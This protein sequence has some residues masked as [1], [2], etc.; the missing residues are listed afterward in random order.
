MI[1]LFSQC[2]LCSNDTTTLFAENIFGKYF[3]CPICKG[4]HLSKNNRMNSSKEKKR[5]LEHNNDIKD[6]GYRNFVSP[7]VTEI[8][9]NHSAI[10]KGLDFGAGPGPVITTML[11]EQNYSVSLYDPFF[12]SDESVLHTTYSY[13]ICCEVMEHFYHPYKEFNTLFSLL[14]DGGKLYCKTHLYDD[15]IHFT[16]WYYSKDHSHVFFYQ[17]DTIEWIKKNIGFANVTISNRLIIFTK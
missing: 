3:L 9:A 6:P 15:S 1:E 17:T 14:N 10:D 4:I 13:I 7:I 11:Q 8:L 5:Y 16:S 12:Y 2:P